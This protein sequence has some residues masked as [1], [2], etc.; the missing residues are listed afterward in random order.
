MRHLERKSIADSL[1]MEGFT[2]AKVREIIKIPKR[3]LILFCCDCRYQIASIVS[4]GYK[5]RNA[6]VYDTPRF[7]TGFGSLFV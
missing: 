5:A 4:F 3:F 2:E 1:I 7:P 6:V